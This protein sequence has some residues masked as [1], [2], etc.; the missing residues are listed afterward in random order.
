[1]MQEPSKALAQASIQYMTVFTK[2]LH[3]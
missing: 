3:T 2:S 1:M